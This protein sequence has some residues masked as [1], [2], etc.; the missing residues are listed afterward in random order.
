M[1]AIYTTREKIK[2]LRENRS[3]PDN[4]AFIETKWRIEP[5]YKPGRDMF[6]DL[7]DS[8]MSQVILSLANSETD[9]I[10]SAWNT[11]AYI[12]WATMKI[13]R[14]SR[15]MR[16]AL[17]SEFPNSIKPISL[18]LDMWGNI[19]ATPEHLTR[20]TLLAQQYLFH[21]YWIDVPVNLVWIASEPW[22]GDEFDEEAFSLLESM[23]KRNIIKFDEYIESDWFLEWGRK[24]IVW[25][26]RDMNLWLKWNKWWANY[27][28]KKLRL[29]WLKWVLNK[30]WGAILLWAN[31]A[32]AKANGNSS[33]RII[34]NTLSELHSFAMLD[35]KTWLIQKISDWYDT[36][37]NKNKLLEQEEKALKEKTED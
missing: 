16:F 23:W 21:R 1:L 34:S 36:H 12:Y 15:N 32:V 13:K 7:K 37:F 2:F 9:G 19:S 33:P 22:K 6:E 4:I 5:D 24:I 8:S 18:W 30:S 29:E 3:V 25:K 31:S 14:S 35:K 10:L 27:I 20:Y 26:A 17:A 11:A 28:M